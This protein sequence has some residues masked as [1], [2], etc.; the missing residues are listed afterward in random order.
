MA[1]ILPS[2]GMNIPTCENNQFWLFH[3]DTK[4]EW[5]ESAHFLCSYYY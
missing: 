5:S 2:L 1:T 3:M 4:F